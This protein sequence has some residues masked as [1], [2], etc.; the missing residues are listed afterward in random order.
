MK[1][2]SF[3]SC[4]ALL[5]A[6]ASAMPAASQEAPDPNAAITAEA[7]RQTAQAALITA[8]TARITAE[9]ERTKAKAAALNL[10]AVA[11]TTTLG[12]GAGGLEAW[13]LSGATINTAA[14]AIAEIVGKTA[15]TPAATTSGGAIIVIGRDEAVNFGLAQSLKEEMTALARVARDTTAEACPK[16]PRA[17]AELASIVPGTIGALIGALKVDTEVR[18]IEVG[19]S[20]RALVNAVSGILD[21]A[22]VPSEAVLPGA[23]SGPLADAWSTLGKAQ[24]AAFM[25]RSKLAAQEEPSD[26]D[27]AYIARMDRALAAVDEY[28]TR[29]THGGQD[30]PSLLVRAGQL[31]AMAKLDPLVLR[32]GLEHAGG[33]L[34][35]RNTVW[36][37]LGA[38]S[39]SLT[40]GLVVSY[41]LTN[42][43]T[44]R[45]S[46]AGLLIC[47]TAHT[48]MKAVHEGKMGVGGCAATTAG[49]P[50][51]AQQR[52]AP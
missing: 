15:K 36:T 9:T 6:L 50:Y 34:L 12:E 46:A 5:G 24:Q 35:K 4:L 31:E 32:V 38:N 42:P 13:M 20:D 26:Q 37:A 28:A 17:G 39:V 40:G 18:G 1:T 2:K 29:A 14:A 21:N 41:R 22:V 49:S 7:A 27:K 3:A 25:C 33:T 48:T 19:A 45:V 52:P 16:D 43:A 10:P 11:G 23:I 44:G 47:R 30:G 51:R 8:G